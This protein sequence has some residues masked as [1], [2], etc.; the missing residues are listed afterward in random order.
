MAGLGV[1]EGV[2]AA[3]QVQG[4]QP[5]LLGRADAQRLAVDFFAASRS[6]TANPLNA[7]VFVNMPCSCL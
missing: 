6:S 1:G 4:Q 5:V 2:P 3:G 7:S